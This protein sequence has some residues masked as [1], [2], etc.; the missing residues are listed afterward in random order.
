MTA[1]ANSATTS[2]QHIRPTR[3][4]HLHQAAAAQ[5]AQ[6]VQAAPA[7]AAAVPTDL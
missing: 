3:T 1:Y 2:T 4:D 5:V 6:A 7:V